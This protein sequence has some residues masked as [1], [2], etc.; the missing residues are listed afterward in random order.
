MRDHYDTETLAKVECALVDDSK[1]TELLGCVQ[2]CMSKEG[3]IQ[4]HTLRN[5]VRYIRDP[6]IRSKADAWYEEWLRMSS[7]YKNVKV[8]ALHRLSGWFELLA[9]AFE[10]L[11]ERKI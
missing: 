4:E 5:I 1:D 6:E 7:Q 2:Y 11:E 10:Y 3:I 8:R 9:E